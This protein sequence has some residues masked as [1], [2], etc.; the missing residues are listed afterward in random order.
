MITL[1]ELK[2]NYLNVSGSTY[3]SQLQLIIDTATK[4]I[5]QYCQQNLL[6]TSLTKEAIV[7]YGR[8]IDIDGCYGVPLTVT[9]VQEKELISDTYTT[10]DGSNYAT[11]T[12]GKSYKVLFTIDPMRYVKITYTQGYTTSNAPSALKQG[13]GQLCV[14]MYRA[15]FMESSTNTFGVESISTNTPAGT[16]TIKYVPL[17]KVVKQ[18]VS[19]WRIA[20]I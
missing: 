17:M 14:E 11:V 5:E 20:R 16:E 8:D 19:D 6:S 9:L 1:T 4:Q 7:Y 18:F 12:D 10:V 2:S 15:S 13:V 3:D